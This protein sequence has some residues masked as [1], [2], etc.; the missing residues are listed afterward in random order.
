MVVRWTLSF[1]DITG[2]KYTVDIWDAT[3]D[4]ATIVTLTG[5]AEPFSTT[6]GE[7]ADMYAPIHG[8]SGYIR[9]AL[10]N[11]T[12]ID[13]LFS[14]KATDRP[15]V[16]TNEDTGEFAW[17]G[18]MSGET[19]NQ[20]WEPLPYTLEIP[21]IGICEAMKGVDF[22]QA[23]GYT[24]LNSLLSTIGGYLPNGVGLGWVKP[25]TFPFDA[26]VRNYNWQTYMTLQEREDA[27]TD[28]VYE[29]STLYD[30]LE[31]FCKYFGMS[32]HEHGNRLIFYTHDADGYT[33]NDGSAVTPA[34]HALESQTVCGSSNKQ[35]RTASY[36]LVTGTFNTNANK[37]E[38]YAA[39]SSESFDDRFKVRDQVNTR[40]VYYGD[41]SVIP[42]L[43][44][45]E[46]AATFAQM[47]DTQ[48]KFFG[49]IMSRSLAN[50]ETDDENY[51]VTGGSA[52]KTDYF[53]LYITITTT[54]D[55]PPLIKIA[56]PN[57]VTVAAEDSALLHIDFTTNLS[58]G[59][60]NYSYGS[61]VY[62]RV[63][64]G[65]YVLQHDTV[66]GQTGENYAHYPF[67]WVKK[68]ELK[69][70]NDDSLVWF[71]HTDGK[72]TLYVPD[73]NTTANA[74]KVL[75][76]TDS[77]SGV[78]LP[79]PDELKGTAAKVE[80]EFAGY[81]TSDYDFSQP[82]NVPEGVTN[83]VYFQV[84][85]FEMSVLFSEVSRGREGVE[86][87]KNKYSVRPTN[88]SASTYSV[89][90]DITTRRS[91]QYGTGLLLDA[92][93][94]YITELYDKEGVQRRAAVVGVPRETIN[95]HVREHFNPFDWLTYAGGWYAVISQSV[96]WRDSDN[97]VSLMQLTDLSGDLFIKES[98]ALSSCIL[99]IDG[100]EYT[101]ENATLYIDDIINTSTPAAEFLKQMA[102]FHITGGPVRYTDNGDP[103]DFTVGKT[104]T[105][106]LKSDRLAKAGAASVSAV[107]TI[108]TAETGSALYDAEGKENGFSATIRLDGREVD[109][110]ETA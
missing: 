50:I 37:I 107:V 109:S 46:G 10:T 17:I 60:T 106:I 66:D 39:T 97:Q 49:Q 76:Y 47:E 2:A 7:N 41:G 83:Y 94:K 98:Y 54:Y 95:V 88:N 92:T 62:A 14:E 33:S 38:D 103:R 51:T 71:L 52:T 74:A 84:T 104:V 67:K 15:V 30:V 73:G 55:F 85:D 72:L 101:I 26:L 25:S 6:E 23:D 27:A 100:V 57:P 1:I 58:S 31:D 3:A 40:K 9:I 110:V 105:A 99:T 21:V 45:T 91:K 48:V 89:E 43:D 11:E 86:A 35:S 79:I 24:S 75:T 12:D 63:R 22:T 34:I 19:Y 8:Q 4:A 81:M 56:I 5:A 64:Y 42:C 18:F 90:A 70:E 102:D 59:A 87:D 20:P 16:V 80:F 29:V 65:D 77:L 68:S 36:R 93:K 28:N 78:Y 32:V 96:A 44:D 69:D 53:Y 61:K 82:D 108:T 13:G